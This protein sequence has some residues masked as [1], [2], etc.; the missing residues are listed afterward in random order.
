MAKAYT[1]HLE[2]VAEKLSL[3]IKTLKGTPILNEAAESWPQSCREKT[4]KAQSSR[5]M[6]RV[7]LVVAAVTGA[8]GLAGV[9]SAADFTGKR[10]DIIVPFTEG[11]GADSWA[12]MVMPHLAKKLPGKPTMVIKN[13]PGGGSVTG[14]NYFDHTAKGDGL[15]LMTASN[16][17]FF[18]YV[19]DKSDKRIKFVPEN[20]TPI[21][22]SPVGAVVFASANSGLKTIED[23]KKPAKEMLVAVA[24]PTGGDTRFL[25][26]LEML[27]IKNKPVYGLDG[28]K[29]AM[30]F[31]RGEI[32][33]NKDTTSAYIR[34]TKP[35]VEQGK[36]FPLF[37][38]GFL[39][40]D[41]TV[42]RDPTFPD[43]P[44][45]VEAYRTFHGKEPSGP[46]FE[47]WMSFFY[48]GVMNSKM[49]VLPAGATQD[50]IDTY[51]KAVKAMIDDPEFK[52][53]AAEEIGAYPQ[54]I[55]DDARKSLKAALF[56]SPESRDYLVKWLKVR[57]GV[58][59]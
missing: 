3:S 44:S 21:I 42:V 7:A 59:L 27:G 12:R 36:A 1:A 16:S 10:I 14:A 54:F 5:Y 51:E 57:Y 31:E 47:A 17:L 15:T 52:A 32:Q 13:M 41:G 30:A 43:M 6:Y 26:T 40:K 46:D 48:I 23:L 53:A 8:V 28:G 2:R 50:V 39:G 56:M 18:T 24:S 34:M 20:W 45:F 49:F 29:G 19:L 33:L 37:T 9:A 38:F 25:L 35:L 11:G 55:G 22:A 4:M 58:T